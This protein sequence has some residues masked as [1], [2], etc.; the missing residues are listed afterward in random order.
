MV[1]GK[2]LQKVPWNKGKLNK[3][4]Q[5]CKTCKKQHL[6]FPTVKRNYCSRECYYK[7]RKG[8][9]SP[10]KGYKW[11]KEQ[12][13]RLSLKRKEDIRLGKR[14]MKGFPLDKNPNWRGGKSFLPYPPEFNKKL[15]D[16]IKMRD[17]NECQAKNVSQCNGYLVIHHIDYD[18]SNC[19]ENNLITVCQGHNSLA[20][21]NIKFW[22][23]YFNG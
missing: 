4:I 20:N 1:F 6:E 5:I 2:G 16:K 21:F 9:Q 7:S 18:K 3:I 10:S 14:V 13:Q 12:K 17:N 15:K 19:K 8:K 23:N 22:R 11:T